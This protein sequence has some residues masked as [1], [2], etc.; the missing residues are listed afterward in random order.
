MHNYSIWRK[1]V[2]KISSLTKKIFAICLALCLFIVCFAGCDLWTRNET[3]YENQVVMRLGETTVT[4]KETYD[5]YYSYGNYYYDGGSTVT[6]NG[7]KQT[8][9]TLLN[10]KLLANNLK[11]GENKIV[12]TQK[13]INDVWLSVYSSLN[14][15]ISSLEKA[16][17]TDEQ[18][19][20]EFDT[21]EEEEDVEDYE[22][23]YESYE[24]TYKYVFN[25]EK[26][27]YELVKVETT[28]TNETTSMDIYQISEEE[29]A[30][31]TTQEKADLAFEN[32]KTNPS[33]W[34]SANHTL[35]DDNGTKYSIKALNKFISQLKAQITDDSLSK[36]SAQIFLRQV[37]KMYDEAYDSKLITVF[38]ENF[39]KTDLITEDLVLRTFNKLARQDAQTYS[40]KDTTDAY[41][42]YTKAMQS[43][44]NPILWFDQASEWFQVSHVLLK[45]DDDTVTELK[46]LKTKLDNDGITEQEY[47]EQ[48]NN[49]KNNVKFTDRETNKT[50]TATEVLLMIQTDVN[51]QTTS[52]MKLQ[53]FNDYIYRFNMDAGANNATLAYYIPTAEANDT[54]VTPFANECRTLR[55]KGVGS[56]S[57]LI[58]L[59]EIDGYTD[60][61]GETQTP[62]YSG[63]HIIIYLGEIETLPTNGE[64]TVEMLN[65]YVLNPLNNNSKYCENEATKT[66]AKTMLDYIIEKISFDNYS[67]YQSNYLNNL[68]GSENPEVNQSVVNQLVDA[69]K[70]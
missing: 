31:M 55:E 64:V 20:E 23:K 68:K 45:F 32:F 3:K 42:D 38:Q 50:Y 56:V 44:E 1:I 59:S 37:Q 16:M 67:A 65:N 19:Q 7:I 17:L 25:S 6:Y 53:V 28:E 41:A 15:T 24:K 8:A 11:N 54:M 9:T 40:L 10:R 30:K 52:D 70:N 49:I 62:S 33:F 2:T 34:S 29:L 51:K 21:E 22:K 13:Q 43:R 14:S 26:N 48:S 57:N 61:S 58:E 5:A 18:I 36:D 12:L 46:A 47:Q 27:K 35:T 63:Y 66:Y 69:F 39:E 60:N 4:L